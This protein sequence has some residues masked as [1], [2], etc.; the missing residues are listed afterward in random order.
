MNSIIA[1]SFRDRN[2]QVQIRFDQT[3]PRGFRLLISRP[4]MLKATNLFSGTQRRN[5]L[6]FG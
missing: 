4:N 1:I 2:N 6:N 5:L 3:F